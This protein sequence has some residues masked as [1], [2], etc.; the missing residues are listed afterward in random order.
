MGWRPVQ[1]CDYQT[2]GSKEYGKQAESGRS[3][4]SRLVRARELVG[5]EQ[6]GLRVTC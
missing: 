1:E 6:Q 4:R 2:V 5:N 3:A